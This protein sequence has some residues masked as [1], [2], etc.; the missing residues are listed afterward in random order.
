MKRIDFYNADNPR[1]SDEIL[2]DLFRLAEFPLQ[3]QLKLQRQNADEP[4]IIHEKNERNE[5]SE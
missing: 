5:W 2:N 1:V 3:V 4:Q